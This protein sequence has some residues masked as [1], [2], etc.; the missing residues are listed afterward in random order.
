[1]DGLVILGLV[2][3]ALRF[4]LLFQAGRIAMHAAPLFVIPAILRLRRGRIL[5]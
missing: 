3:V 4:T 5:R 2:A 1:V